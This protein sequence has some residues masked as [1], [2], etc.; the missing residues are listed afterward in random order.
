M[1]YKNVSTK[2]NLHRIKIILLYLKYEDFKITKES[3]DI[4]CFFYRN[5]KGENSRINRLW[6]DQRI[7]EVLKRDDKDLYEYFKKKEVLNKIIEF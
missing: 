6:K 3:E 5:K 1:K 7:K 2:G 4:Q